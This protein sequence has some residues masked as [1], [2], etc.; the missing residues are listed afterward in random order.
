MGTES[1]QKLTTIEEFT[2]YWGNEAYTKISKQK[3]FTGRNKTKNNG[4]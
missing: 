4:R 3:V 2:L 1:S